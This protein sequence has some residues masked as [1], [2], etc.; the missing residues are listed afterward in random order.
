[1]KKHRSK[2]ALLMIL[3]L[4]LLMAS[5][6]SDEYVVLS[7]NDLGMHCANKDFSNIVILPPYNNLKAQDLQLRMKFLAILIQLAKQISGPI[8]KDCLELLW[9]ISGLPEPG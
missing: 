5:V 2:F 6:T 8:R 3:A 7:W 9:Q 4:P 1:M